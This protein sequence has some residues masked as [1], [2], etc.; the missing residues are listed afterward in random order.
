VRATKGVVMNAESTTHSRAELV[1]EV[2]KWTVGAGILTVALAPLSIPIL[3]LTAI[4]LLPL[5]LP[6]IPIALIAGLLYLPIRLVRSLRR[7]RRPLARRE[8]AEEEVLIGIELAPAHHRV[9]K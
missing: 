7:R 9:V 3:A 5:L 1:D 2:S 4:A 8:A 6:L